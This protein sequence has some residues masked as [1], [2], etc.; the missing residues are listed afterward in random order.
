MESTR[1]SLAVA[2]LPTQS[3]VEEQVISLADAM[4]GTEWRSRARVKVSFF[5][6]VRSEQFA[7]DV[8]PCIDMSRGGVSF[9]SQKAY[10]KKNEN[11][12]CGAFF[13]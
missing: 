11:A 4:D 1:G 8:V 5:A 13:A 3:Q 7:D 6:C 10:Q 12:D 2:E 9:R